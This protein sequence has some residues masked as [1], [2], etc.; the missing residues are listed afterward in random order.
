MPKSQRLWSH[1]Y[2]YLLDQIH[3]MK[4]GEN[5]L[6]PEEELTRKLGVSRSTVREATQALLQEGY[7]DRKSVV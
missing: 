7:L 3:G 4:A 5:Q 6:E 2:T 1:T